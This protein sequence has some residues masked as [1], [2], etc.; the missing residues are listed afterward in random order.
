MIAIATAVAEHYQVPYDRLVSTRQERGQ[1]WRDPYI[2][3]ARQ[4]AM[5]LIRQIMDASYP[6]IG[7]FFHMDHT[8][9][10]A[11]IRRIM[12]SLPEQAEPI[13]DRMLFPGSVVGHA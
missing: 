11:G 9:V 4:V 3:E 12:S 2:V 5:V 6:R 8:T 13:V 10:V 7:R 1:R